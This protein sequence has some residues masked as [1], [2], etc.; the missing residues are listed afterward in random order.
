M[1]ISPSVDRDELTGKKQTRIR[2]KTCHKTFVCS[3]EKGQIE[4]S[5]NQP[6]DEY[7]WTR[8]EL[9]YDS[10]LSLKSCYSRYMSAEKGGK[11]ITSR[12]RKQLEIFTVEPLNSEKK[13]GH[14]NNLW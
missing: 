8:F 7:I 3:Q 10:T 9:G 6:E 11:L 12:T 1:S 13:S 5:V 14:K 4:H 2:I